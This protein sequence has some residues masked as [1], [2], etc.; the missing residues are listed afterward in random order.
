MR[1]GGAGAARSDAKLREDGAR[2]PPL[3]AGQ[4]SPAAG[5]AEPGRRHRRA[6]RSRRRSSAAARAGRTRLKDRAPSGAAAG[7]SLPEAAT[8]GAALKGER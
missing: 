5:A 8:R 7:G 1:W 4:P 6:R 3:L 2:E